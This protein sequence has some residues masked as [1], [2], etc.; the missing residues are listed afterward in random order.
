MNRRDRRAA[1]AQSRTS[2]SRPTV[3][4]EE[5]LRSALA[6]HQAGKVDAAVHVYRQILQANPKHA[7]AM[8]FLGLA[9]E[10]RGDVEQGLRLMVEAVALAPHEFS[11]QSNLGNAFFKAGNLDE[12]LKAFDAAVR[13]KPTLAEPWHNLGVVH[14]RK[15]NAD[16]AERAYREALRL[17]ADYVD[18]H[19][20]LGVLLFSSGKA[21][22]AARHFARAAEL[23]PNIAAVHD[24]LANT[25]AAQ[26]KL[27][28]AVLAYRRAIELDPRYAE[29]MS[30]LGNT[31]RE[32]HLFDDAVSAYRRAL[33]I[34][35][36][37]AIAR[38]NLATV[39]L[40]LG[41][42]GEAV[43]EYRRAVAA[44]PTFMRAHA[45]L[46]SALQSDPAI[47]REEL[48]DEHRA[49]GAKLE[50]ALAA[51]ATFPNDWSPARKLRIAYVSADLREH[52]VAYFI[53]TVLAHHD[54]G[55]FEIFVY[56]SYAL[57]D[58]VT[59]R[60]RGLVDHWCSAATMRDAELAA[61]VRED[62][63]DALFDLS[64]HS[65]Q[66]RLVTFALEPAPVQFTWIGYPGTTGLSRIDYRIVD[67]TTDPE[68][69]DAYAVEKLVRLDPCFLCYSPPAGLPP[70][71]PAP[72][73]AS[74]RV[75]FGS[76]NA[77]H[78]VGADVLDTWARILHAVPGSRLVMKSNALGSASARTRIH[79]AFARAKV[80][81]ERVDLRAWVADP[82]AHLS[83]Y[84]EID[85]ALDTHPYNGTTTTCEALWMGVPTVTRLGDRHAS[86]VGASL[87]RA[88]GL[89][90]WVAAGP[91]E[92]VQIAISRAK[93]AAALAELRA[94]LRER[95][96]ASALGDGAAFTRRFEAMLR[97]RWTAWCAT[98]T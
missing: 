73:L 41:E 57:E 34:R 47:S 69:A 14:A 2:P 8:H 53:E 39:L 78:K 70:V 18:A 23:A 7:T 42:G 90:D 95:A 45:N 88:A 17:R 15:G 16:A 22:E 9:L 13:S 3:D 94:G 20:A 19:V 33:A 40:Q 64:G 68:D 56:Y 84:D 89:G 54:R 28:E 79:D 61:R 71:A 49:F 48:A 5:Q 63:I 50:S 55:A 96:R 93:D 85:I 58:R 4:W 62:R 24:H 77:L 81:A 38:N 44:D 30:N 29:A 1:Q 31:L 27:D 59:E 91:E 97:D 11:F 52:S 32:M 76:F 21:P 80:P 12:A 37:L 35:P 67:S 65:A 60:L 66:S 98:P 74:G 43:A 87:M 75:T 26:G 92:Y 82:G 72:C 10:Q 36:E 25:L 86:R 6:N 83:T 51:P 46:L